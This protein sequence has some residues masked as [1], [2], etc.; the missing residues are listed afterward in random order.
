MGRGNDEVSYR[1]SKHLTSD[2][3]MSVT[4]FHTLAKDMSILEMQ[5]IL[6]LD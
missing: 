6:Y 5:H 1:D 3:I 2:Y 4:A